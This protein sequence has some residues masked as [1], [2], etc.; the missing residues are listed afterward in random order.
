MTPI[1]LRG[2]FLALL[3]VT[4]AAAQQPL[5]PPVYDLASSPSLTLGQVQRGE[6]TRDDARDFINGGYLDIWAIPSN[7]NEVL[8][9]RITT[10]HGHIFFGSLFAPDGD[11]TNY[12]SQTSYAG[13]NSITSVIARIDAPGVYMLVVSGY[14]P[15]ALGAYTLERDS[16]A[17]GEGV[18]VN[19]SVPDRF[20]RTLPFFATDRL[21]FTLTE[22]KIISASIVAEG[23]DAYLGLQG[24]DDNYNY[25]FAAAFYGQEARL[26]QKLE[27][28]RYV[29]T[30]SA[31]EGVG[32]GT[33]A[34]D[35]DAVEAVAMD[36]VD[37]TMPD[38]F[39]DVY[40]EPMARGVFRLVLTR[41]VALE[42]SVNSDDFN[43]S[44]E[45]FE[46]A[47]NFLIASDSDPFFRDSMLYVGISA[48]TYLLVVTSM[49]EGTG[50]FFN[51]SVNW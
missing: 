41:D 33:Y 39:S 37:I 28:G 5:K 36:V 26:R 20:T 44:L 42:V 1:A 34:V 25:D 11:V 3:L 50:G 35:I 49:V 15:D 27:P 29:L 13:D 16:F 51:L 7:G 24:A 38:V 22:P 46:E 43:T 19:V 18:N 23:F 12:R 10:S 32:S 2:S 21:T 8:E 45:I 40:L 30:I 17:A 48:G 6:L 9:I 4:V 47:N 31:A 14:G